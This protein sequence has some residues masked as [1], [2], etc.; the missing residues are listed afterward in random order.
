MDL[1]LISI[2]DLI[3]YRFNLWDGI[4]FSLFA[5]WCGQKHNNTTLPAIEPSIITGYD[6]GLNRSTVCP[7][8]DLCDEGCYYT[9]VKFFRSVSGKKIKK[10][11]SI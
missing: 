11:G 3:R 4:W 5:A 10:D 9:T 8:L 1:W 6:H 2:L 7:F